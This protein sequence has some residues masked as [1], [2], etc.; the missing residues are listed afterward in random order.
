MREG[1]A[2]DREKCPRLDSGPNSRHLL[3]PTF[4]G[5]IVDNDTSLFV[6][7]HRKDICLSMLSTDLEIDS[8][9]DNSVL[10]DTQEKGQ[11]CF[12]SRN[13]VLKYEKRAITSHFSHC[14]QHVESFFRG[15]ELKL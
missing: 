13:F 7:S 12:N 4:N 6:K 14:I 8:D 10:S 15:E 3:F 9:F 5:P 1:K 2:P 11:E